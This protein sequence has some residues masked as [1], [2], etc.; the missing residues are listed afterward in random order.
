MFQ[1]KLHVRDYECDMQGIVNNAIYQHYFEHA[2]HIFLK[3]H[4][5]NFFEMVRKEI[6]LVIYR[7]EIDYLQP[8]TYDHEFTVSVDF[9]Q[10]SKV[11]GVF[12]QNIFIDNVIYTK[13]QFFVTA[14]DKNK[15][16]M[17]FDLIQLNFN[18][19]V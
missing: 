2:R 1:I 14:V 9:E 6:F 17:N 15:K 10:I 19:V 13:G 16:P 3:K 12:K 8:L 5:S 4:G 7:A 11:R 18:K